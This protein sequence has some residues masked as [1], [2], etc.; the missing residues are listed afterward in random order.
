MN[1]F[2]YCAVYSQFTLPVS[3]SI[4]LL[5]AATIFTVYILLMS[6]KF[7]GALLQFHCPVSISSCICAPS[8]CLFVRPSVL[9]SFFLYLTSSPSLVKV[10]LFAICLSHPF[11]RTPSMKTGQF[12]VKW[13]Q[14]F[15]RATV[16]VCVCVCKVEAGSAARRGPK[17]DCHAKKKRAGVHADD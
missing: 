3:V 10:Q 15:L 7:T 8:I 17:C 4:A 9:H 5:H 16:C 12:G 2:S 6:T 1:C 14:T 11:T 13:R